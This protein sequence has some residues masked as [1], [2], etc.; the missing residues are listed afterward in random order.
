[1]IDDKGLGARDLSMESHF[2]AIGFWYRVFGV[3]TFLS[4]VFLISSS[5]MKGGGMKAGA[6][7]EFPIVFVLLFSSV[8][9]FSV[10]HFMAKFSNAA[11]IFCVFALVIALAFTVW[12]IVNSDG[13]LIGIKKVV[14]IAVPSLLVLF[15]IS[16][17]YVLSIP[18]A[19]K[20][21]RKEYQELLKKTPEP[22]TRPSDSP[23]FW[24][25][26]VVVAAGIA[27]NL[28]LVMK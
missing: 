25:F 28:I 21:C 20:V 5:M 3:L 9:Q 14:S 19:A 1:M 15:S 23:F 17:L 7:G 10:G 2:L 22:K 27:G 26:A 13:G 24:G 18:R 4:A 12:S 16:M 6:G 11:R 8:L